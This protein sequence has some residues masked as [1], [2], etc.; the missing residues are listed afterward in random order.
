MRIFLAMLDETRGFP[1]PETW[2][3]RTLPKTLL[4]VARRQNYSFKRC[5]SHRIHV[6]FEKF[7]HTWGCQGQ[8]FNKEPYCNGLKP[9]DIY[10]MMGGRPMTGHDRIQRSCRHQQSPGPFLDRFHPPSSFSLPWFLL[11]RSLQCCRLGRAT[12]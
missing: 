10:T 6:R 5:F 8:P 3:Q 11:Y 2:A 12:L 1:G 9:G 7:L 4:Y